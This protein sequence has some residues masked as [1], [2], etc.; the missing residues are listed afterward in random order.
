MLMMSPNKA[1]TQQSMVL[2]V[3]MVLARRWPGWCLACH[4]LL[5]LESR[6]CHMYA[7]SC[8]KKKQTKTKQNCNNNNKNIRMTHLYG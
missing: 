4:L 5:F 2:R 6:L 8:Q 3:R 1:K 7:N